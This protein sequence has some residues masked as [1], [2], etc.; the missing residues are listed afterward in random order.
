[1]PRVD[2]PGTDASVDFEVEEDRVTATSYYAGIKLGSKTLA[3]TEANEEG[4]GYYAE[5]TEFGIGR[6]KVE[7]WVR[8]AER[9][10]VLVCVLH[11]GGT[12]TQKEKWIDF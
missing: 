12:R 1:M 9:K 11:I 10:I 8:W 7:V 6:A 2:I 4:F 3:I 5:R